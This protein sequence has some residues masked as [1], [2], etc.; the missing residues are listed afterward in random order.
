[1]RHSGF[2]L[3][4]LLVVI[5]ISAVVTVSGFTY[6]G[7][8]RSEQNLKLTTSEVLSVIKNTQQSSKS[9]QG[10]SKW[11]IRFFNTT[12][13]QYY[14]VFSGTSFDLGTISKSYYLGRNISFANP[15]SSSTIDMIFNASTGNP[16][17][18]QIISL[19][20]N[21]GDGFVGDIVANTLGIISSKFDTGL[22]GYWHFDEN[23]SSTA[24]DSSGNGNNGTLISSPTWQTGANCKV[25]SCLNFNGSNYVNV[26]SLN[27]S[28][29]KPITYEVWV[30][31][32]ST[33]SGQAIFGRDT[34]GNTTTGI[35]GIYNYDAGT[36][37]TNEFAYYTGGYIFGSNYEIVTGQWTHIVFTW[38]ANNVATWYVNGVQTRSA[39]FTATSNA[40][41]GFQ[42]GGR[43][44]LDSFYNGLID[45]VRVY[46]RALSATDVSDVY[47]SAR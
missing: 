19:T 1:M 15:G 8:Y 26:S 28:S 33:A 36:S 24:Y 31:P 2:T 14:S 47:N 37:A 43:S 39:S 29:Y 10:G 20:T 44:S 42:I 4:E 35:I 11:G 34:S 18:N 46:N 21:R 22:V 7:G 45:E 12:S 30:K 27:N 13:S 17:Q 16:T 38:D 9:Q 23:T 5:A 6:L 41:I 3:I 40:N 25:G 32:N